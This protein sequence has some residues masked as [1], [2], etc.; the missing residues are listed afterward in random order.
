[1]LTRGTALTLFCGV[2]IPELAAGGEV[3]EGC[4]FSFCFPI[5]DCME[6]MHPKILHAL[7]PAIC[8]AVLVHPFFCGWWNAEFINIHLTSEKSKESML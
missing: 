4:S 7:L 5:K 1:M 3:P 8:S 6:K 2:E